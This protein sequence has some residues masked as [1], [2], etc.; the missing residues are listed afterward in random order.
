MFMFRS[1]AIIAA[2]I[3]ILLVPAAWSAS[4]ALNEFAEFMSHRNVLV[5]LDFTHGSHKLTEGSQKS[6]DRVV[7]DL[8]ALLDDDKVIRIEG[9]AT[10]EGKDEYS[11]VLSMQRAM[12]VQ[13]YLMDR[14]GFELDLYFNGY[15]SGK[16]A[17][18][19]RVQIAFYDDS[20]G[21]RVANIDSVITQ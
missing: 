19:K 10:Q 1:L 3:L 8:K 6:L 7:G 16:V 18:E 15:G 14:Y 13:S 2:L 21:L 11:L 20:L 17:A 4:D 5:S 9:Y 12:E